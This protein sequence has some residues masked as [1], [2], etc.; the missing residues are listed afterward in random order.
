VTHGERLLEL[1]RKDPG[2]PLVY[3][4]KIGF[5]S[6]DSANFRYLIKKLVNDGKLVQRLETIEDTDLSILILY[7]TEGN[8]VQS[9]DN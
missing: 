8:H 7:P 6:M 9:G 5:K 1:V 2:K 4:K 3:Y